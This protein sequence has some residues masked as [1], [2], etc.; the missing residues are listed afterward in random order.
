MNADNRH[1]ANQELSNMTSAGQMRY[2]FGFVFAPWLTVSRSV[3]AQESERGNV[4]QPAR[5]VDMQDAAATS[6]A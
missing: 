5:D 6:T 2:V 3:G 1:R 4:S